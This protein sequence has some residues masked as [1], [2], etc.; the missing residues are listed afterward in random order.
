MNNQELSTLLGTAIIPSVLDHVKGGELITEED[1]A[2]FYKSH[3]YELLSDPQTAL[4]HLSPASL[5]QMYVEELRDGHFEVPEEQ[6]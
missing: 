1:I 5:G 3:L 4:W 2:S 6:S